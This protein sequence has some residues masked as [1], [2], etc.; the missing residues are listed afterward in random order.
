MPPNRLA[1]NRA[2]FR[3]VNER[4]RELSLEQELVPWIERAEYFCECGEAGCLERI[5]LTPAEF[6]A[7]RSDESTFV[8]SPRHVSPVFAI[9]E[10][11]RDYLI[12]ERCD[13]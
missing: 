8:I 10:E 1:Q 5:E 2:I 7:A 6:E 12:V 4:V 9:V 3:E 11:M 13:P